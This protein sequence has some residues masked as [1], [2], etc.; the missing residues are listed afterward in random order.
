MLL[1]L[2]C[3]TSFADS[4]NPY[5]RGPGPLAGALTGFIDGING[6]H[7]RRLM[8]E[9][10]AIDIVNQQIK[11][12]QQQIY[13]QQMQIDQMQRQQQQLETDRAFERI[14]NRQP[15]EIK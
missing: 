3:S 10:Q 2:A 8:E 11:Q 14:R 12:Q 6:S 5:D 4:T 13:M 15:P 7:N 1:V 9:R